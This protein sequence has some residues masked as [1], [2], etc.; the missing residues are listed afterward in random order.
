[1]FVY[2]GIGST[3]TRVLYVEYNNDKFWYLNDSLHRENDQPAAIDPGAHYKAWYFHGSFIRNA[4][5]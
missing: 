2:Q 4:I 1:M 3:T 5:G